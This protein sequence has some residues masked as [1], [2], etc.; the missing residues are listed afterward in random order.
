MTEKPAK[1]IKEFV[2]DASVVVK[3]FSREPNHER[4]KNLLKKLE[5]REIDLFTSDLLFYEVGNALFRGKKLKA[6]EINE[7]LF[8]LREIPINFLGL[9][10]GRIETS[11]A[12]MERYNLTFYDAIYAALAKEFN[13]PLISA[14]PKDH[15]KIKEIKIIV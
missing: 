13:A 12:L 5:N 7:A 10:P 2:I 15:K 8:L 9:D 3:W 1:K 4:A 14:N 11:T 6:A